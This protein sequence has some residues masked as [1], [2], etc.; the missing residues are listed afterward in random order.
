[1]KSTLPAA[2]IQ[3]L[4]GLPG[5]DRESFCRA[6]EYPEP[7]TAIRLN[8]QKPFD[9]FGVY[10]ALEP[11]PW[12]RWGYYLPERPLFVFDPLWHA[13]AYYVQEASSMFLEQCVRQCVDP[14]SSLRALD[15]CAAPGGK[16]TLLQ[17]LLSANS[18]LVSNEVI[19]SRAP[20]L[21][22]NLSKWG[23]LNSLVVNNDPRELGRMAEYFDLILVDAPCSGSGLFRKDPAA[24]KEWSPDAALMCSRRQQRILSDICPSLKKGGI[25]I[26]STC[27][28]SAEENEDMA[29]WLCEQFNLSPLRIDAPDPWSITETK[30]RKYGAFGYRFFPDKLKGEGFYISC[31]KKEEGARS[32]RLVHKKPKWSRLPAKDEAVVRPWLNENMPVNLYALDG[33]V[34]A[35]PS[36]LEQEL[37]AAGGN[38]YLKKAGARIGKIA[39]GELVPAHELA[40]S[41][42]LN[43]KIVVIPLK[44]DQALQ[45]LRKE[46]VTI[47]MEYK[48][49]ATVQYEGVNLGWVK[50][51]GSRINNYYPKEWRILKTE[52]NKY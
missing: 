18:L 34:F 28:Y 4:E 6:H 13:G 7:A 41:A 17:S 43:E 27:S 22:E 26:Y 47:D 1:V 10:G 37:E 20:I 31:F 14:S 45:Y 42:A 32:E 51:L 35:F 15:L 46:T 49:W 25:L 8:P 5:F 12:S 21:E 29:D 50:V 48:G 39:Q 36:A 2:F 44:K 16:S 19:K 3:S 38:L 9:V 24:I 33:E 40:L 30:S 11:V 23:G 52:K